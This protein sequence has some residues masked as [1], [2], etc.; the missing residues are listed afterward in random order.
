MDS[1]SESKIII[2]I[3]SCLLG[4]TV[5]W[6]GGHKKDSYIDEVLG[7]FFDWVHV[8]PEMDVG[9]GVPREPVHLTGSLENLR[10][11]G[12][13]SK[14][15]WTAKMLRYSR[16]RINELQ[17]LKIGGFIFKNNSPS[18]GIKGINI[19][20]NKGRPRPVGVGLFANEFIKRHPVLPVEE[21]G[22]LRDPRIRENFLVRVFS[23]QRLQQLMDSRFSRAG[24]IDFHTHHK[25]L[26]L[27]HDRKKYSALD[28]L[29]AQS[30][31]LSP[32]KFRHQYSAL[33]MR[34]LSTQT[35]VKKNVDVL[36]HMLRYVKIYLDKEDKQDILQSIGD[37]HQ[38]RVPLVVPLTL[39]KHY[40][41]KYRIEA[42]MDQVYLNPHPNELLLRNH[43]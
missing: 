41:R 37:Y 13:Q 22:R 36:Q 6:N 16:G 2:G 27:A 12:K 43:V 11:V 18:C 17:S 40:G 3:S 25:F 1:P 33:F 15:D 31:Q 26:L 34:V 39:I 9:M 35:T 30:K 20:P 5:R 14:A 19:Y 10:L 21:E 7:Q 28:R 4:E 38:G 29:V 32:A 42:L 8:C 24:I 23:Y